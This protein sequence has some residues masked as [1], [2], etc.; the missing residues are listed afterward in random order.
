M[1]AELSNPLDE[2]KQE[3]IQKIVNEFVTNFGQ[4]FPGN[5]RAGLS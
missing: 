2:Q 1:G 3:E 4:I 5:A